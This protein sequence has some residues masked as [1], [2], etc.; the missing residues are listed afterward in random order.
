MSSKVYFTDFHCNPGKSQLEKLLR[1]IKQGGIDKI[2][3]KDKFVAIKIHFGEWGNMSFL[4]QQYAKVVC[5]YIKEKGGK[6][7]LT[8]CNTLYAGYRQ[9]ALD[10]LDAAY[11]N[12]YNPLATGVHTIIADGLRGTEE[13]CIPITGG[14]YFKE[15]MIGSAIADAD[16]LISMTHFKGHIEAGFG[17]TIKNI[18]MGCGSKRGKMAMHS[19][20]TPVIDKD[21]CIGCGMCVKSCAN[22]GVHV[23]QD[24]KAEIDEEHCLGCGHC[25]AFCPRGA[26]DCKWDEMGVALNEKIAEYAKAVLTGKPAFHISFVKEVSPNCDC[27]PGNDIAIVPDV[28]MFC[29]FDPVALDHACADA[30]NSQP[31]IEGSYVDKVSHHRHEGEDLSKLMY[32]ESGWEGLFEHCEK[33]G[34]GTREYEIVNVK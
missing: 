2:D 16:I 13:R 33:L 24:H 26:I 5:D 34:L 18:G 19:N 10:H 6:P 9:N 27:N 31:I 1:M 20:S 15:A 22:D 14:K 8:D 25:F 11:Q 28:G 12:G 4:R 7:F 30:V 17:G 29:S 32:P 23:L 3:F 21:V